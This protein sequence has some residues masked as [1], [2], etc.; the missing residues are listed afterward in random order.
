MLA[1][2]QLLDPFLSETA[3]AFRGRAEV[4]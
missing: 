3:Q 1:D 2:L 4:R